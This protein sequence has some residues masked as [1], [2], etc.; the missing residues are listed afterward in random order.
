MIVAAWYRW[1][2]TRQ[3]WWLCLLVGI[4]LLDVLF[5]SYIVAWELR[6]LRE[7]WRGSS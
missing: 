5:A 1:V 4:L 6:M 7:A 2:Q 3:W